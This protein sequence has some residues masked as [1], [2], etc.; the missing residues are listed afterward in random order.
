M[1]FRALAFLVVLP[2]VAF[3]AARMLLPWR[4]FVVPMAGSFELAHLVA[5]VTFILGFLA[6]AQSPTGRRA[7]GE[8]DE[9]EPFD[10]EEPFGNEDKPPV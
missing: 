10:P 3:V 7:R 5:L 6:W 1:I 9:D 2:L 8:A 4:G